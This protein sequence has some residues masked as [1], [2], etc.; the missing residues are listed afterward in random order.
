MPTR[1]VLP[2]TAAPPE[3]GCRLPILYGLAAPKAVRHGA[4]TSIIAPSAP[5]PLAVHPI[6]RRRVT[7]PLCQNPS[8]RSRSSL[9]LFLSAMAG[10]SGSL[11]QIFPVIATS[12]TAKTS[13]AAVVPAAD[14]YSPRR[15]GLS[16]RFQLSFGRKIVPHTIPPAR[17]GNN[18]QGGAD[19]E[20]C[21]H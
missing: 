7:L 9:G 16:R 3:S 19:L 20:S 21:L 12:A 15:R 5:A 11:G 14:V 18:R 10:P 2:P 13:I 17:H 1:A 6:R 4:G 8:S